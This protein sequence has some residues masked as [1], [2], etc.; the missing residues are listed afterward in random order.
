MQMLS[1]HFYFIIK[2]QFNLAPFCSLND[3]EQ[4]SCLE[5]RLLINQEHEFSHSSSI[6]SI[7]IQVIYGYKDMIKREM[8]MNILISLNH[9]I[10][11]L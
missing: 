6:F 1:L 3:L 4:I 9:Y 5:T 11:I 7:F 2:E 10:T 8:F